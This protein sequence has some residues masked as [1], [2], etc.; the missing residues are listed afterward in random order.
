MLPFTVRLDMLCTI[1]YNYVHMIQISI[2]RV[3]QTLPSLINRVFAGEEFVVLK[4][5]IP[6]AKIVG[7]SKTKTQTIKRKILPEAFGMWKNRWPKSKSSKDIVNEW[8][9]EILYGKHDH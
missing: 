5:K 8:R 7:I 2:S 1:L 4:N 3:R 9:N 6:V